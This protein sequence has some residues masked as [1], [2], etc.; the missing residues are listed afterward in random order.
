MMTSFS[1]VLNFVQEVDGIEV[2][3][4]VEAVSLRLSIQRM[5]RDDLE[6]KVEYIK[7]NICLQYSAVKS[8]YYVPLTSTFCICII[9]IEFGKLWSNVFKKINLP[10]SPRDKLF[11]NKLGMEIVNKYKE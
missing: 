9:S 5:L 2:V 1:L 11:R 3:I 8:Y 4:P 7:K 6:K 10:N